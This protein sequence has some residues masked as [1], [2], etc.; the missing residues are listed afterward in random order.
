MR[1]KTAKGKRRREDSGR[2]EK[3]QREEMDW[4]P[5]TEAGKK[6]RNEEITSF[7]QLL[8]SGLPVIEP[9]IIDYLI[10]E[11]K[12]KLVEFNKTAK[13][14]S[15]GRVFSFRASVLVGDGEEFIGVGIAK[16]KEKMPAIRK[17]TNRAK[18]NLVKVRK[19][20]GSW[21]CTCGTHHSIPFKVEGKAASVRV[22]LMPAPKGTGLVVGSNI[23]DVFEFIG[24]KDIWSASKGSTGTKLNFIRA[25]I[26][27][28]SKTTEMKLSEETTQRIDK[29]KRKEEIEVKG[30]E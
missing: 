4:I 11:L 18:L 13:V 7:Q 2:I 21:E 24:I 8:D 14:R 9:Q 6:V 25:A 1:D 20:C 19:G 15:A 5:R 10:P 30:E 27:A 3:V 12:E 23:K 29:R 26:D 17:A 22:I 16:D 28:L